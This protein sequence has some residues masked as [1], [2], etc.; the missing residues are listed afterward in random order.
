M[1]RIFEF[2]KF[3]YK[4]EKDIYIPSDI[5]DLFIKHGLW[6]N[7]V[8]ECI[9]FLGE[10]A[11]D[12]STD[13]GAYI[14]R[15]Y[16]KN[17]NILSEIINNFHYKGIPKVVDVDIFDKLSKG[18]TIWYRGVSKDKYIDDLKYRNIFNGTN[19]MIQGTWITSNMEYAMK[20]TVDSPDRLI[21]CL[22]SPSAKIYDFKNDVAIRNLI[23]AL[24]DDLEN[25]IRYSYDNDEYRS[26][27]KYK[28][29]LIKYISEYLLSNKNYMCALSGSDVYKE[30]DTVMIVLNKEKLIICK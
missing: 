16:R 9:L 24:R 29:F 11:K 8:A 23:D 18:K 15:I 17:I 27:G 4:K 5:K 10:F 6:N 2:K 26:E 14:D 12:L 3:R 25:I 20:Y 1:K 21:K 7:A 28:R 13:K 22:I 19:N 30:S